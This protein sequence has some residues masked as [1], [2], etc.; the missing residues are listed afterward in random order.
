MFGL[1]GCHL[2]I[3]FWRYCWCQRCGH[4]SKSPVLLFW[5]LAPKIR[6]AV[7]MPLHRTMSAQRIGPIYSDCSG[8]KIE[9]VVRCY[10]VGRAVHQA[11]KCSTRLGLS[12]RPA[13][14]AGSRRRPP[15]HYDLNKYPGSTFSGPPSLYPDKREHRRHSSIPCPI[16]CCR[17][18]S[19]KHLFSWLM[20]LF[21]LE[22]SLSKTQLLLQPT[23]PHTSH[24]PKL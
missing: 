3:I 10:D 1:S 9:K 2:T 5:E 7:F 14:A 21:Q 19:V 11:F 24:Q 8:N 17:H 16:S 15:P 20:S 6:L 23:H 13:L 4:P 12:R 22:L 18:A